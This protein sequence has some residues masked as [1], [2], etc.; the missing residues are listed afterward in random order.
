MDAYTL[1]KEYACRL[2]G[3]LP[4]ADAD[5]VLAEDGFFYDRACM[6]AYIKMTKVGYDDTII[7]P[8]TNESIGSTLITPKTIKSLI[9]KLI[10]D[11]SNG[12]GESQNE[13]VISEVKE[14]NL[15]DGDLLARRAL[16]IYF[17][18]N[19]NTKN[20][21]LGYELLVEA[22]CDGGSGKLCATAVILYWC[23]STNIAD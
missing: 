8:V 7:S 17:G 12:F 18:R 10:D 15:S 5:I 13:D 6:N 21:A 11:E 3:R 2:C 20:Q 9:R 22:A 23:I 16:D 19:N 1:M 14:S 4:S